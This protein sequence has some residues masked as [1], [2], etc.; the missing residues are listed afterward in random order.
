MRSF[1]KQIESQDGEYTAQYISTEELEEIIGGSQESGPILTD[2]SDIDLPALRNR[3]G[4]QNNKDTGK[5]QLGKMSEFGNKFKGQNGAKLGAN[6]V[7]N[8]L[9]NMNEYTDSPLGKKVSE[10]AKNYQNSYNKALGYEKEIESRN[11]FSRFL[12]GGNKKLAQNLNEEVKQNKEQ[13]QS[14]LSDLETAD[15]EETT[16][17]RE[18]IKELQT[19]SNRMEGIANQEA[20]KKGLFRWW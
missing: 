6:G 11:G 5:Q 17:I 9:K 4:R 12:F 14:L 16:L 2:D 1:I 8:N 15:E 10:F 13:V 3:M 18:Q 20:K 7:I 19:E